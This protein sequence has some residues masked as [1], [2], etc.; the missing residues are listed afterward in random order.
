VKSIPV[1]FTLVVIALFGHTT[2]RAQDPLP[3]WNDG[4]TKQA[5]VDF[6][7]TTTEAGG[8]RFVPPE[9]RI[10][11]FD[12]DGT[13][14]VEHPVY[15]QLIYCLDRVPVLAKEKPELKNVEPFKT[16]LSGDLEAIAKLPLPELLKIVAATLTGMTNEEFARFVTAT[17]YVTVAEIAPTKEEFPNAPP[18]NLVAGS[19]VF[20]PTAQPV[21]LDDYTQWWRYVHGANWRHPTGP[22]SD[23]KGKEKYPVVQVCYTD[24]VAYAKWADKRLPT[25]ALGAD[26][27]LCK[28]MAEAVDYF[29]LQFCD[30]GLFFRLLRSSRD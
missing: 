26:R 30:A 3:S 19:M 22:D 6:V 2:T 9:E 8:A 15:T 5:I 18:E 25:E 12:Q 24:S 29:S 7:R 17:G 20:T 13:L 21:P 27:W 28:N 11:T 10:A 1:T 4:P 16:V 23:L 14:R